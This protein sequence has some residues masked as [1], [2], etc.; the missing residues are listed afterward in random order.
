MDALRSAGAEV[1]VVERW[2]HRARRRVD[3]FGMFDLLAI[4]DG[5]IV[6]VQVCDHSTLKRHLDLIRERSRVARMWLQAGGEIEV[7][8]WRK[9]GGR[10]KSEVITITE[11]ELDDE[12]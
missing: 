6:G 7:W 2:L 1:T 3:A 11:D 10:W 9:S 12:A 8:S 5:R 4:R